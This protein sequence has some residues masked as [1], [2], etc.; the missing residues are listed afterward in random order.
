MFCIFTRHYKGINTEKLSKWFANN[1]KVASMNQFLA[2]QR[3][4][5]MMAVAKM[6]CL[7]LSTLMSLQRTSGG[8]K[9]SD[10]VKSKFVGSCGQIC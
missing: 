2:W 9:S 3:I 6:M 7:L 4:L 8:M 10:K 1:L 5:I